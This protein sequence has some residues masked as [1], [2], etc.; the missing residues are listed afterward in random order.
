MITDLEEKG[1][2]ERK[3]EKNNDDA[4]DAQISNRRSE[5]QASTFL[6][7]MIRFISS[8]WTI[9]QPHLLSS[10][11]QV[12]KERILAG[13]PPAVPQMLCPKRQ[14]SVTLSATGGSETGIKH[15]VRV[16]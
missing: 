12:F 8:H 9:R 15:H 3:R 10:R 2:I 7:S 4:P 13:A 1:R 16:G 14:G 6:A 5:L 11:L